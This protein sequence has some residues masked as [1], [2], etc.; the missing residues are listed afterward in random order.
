MDRRVLPHARGCEHGY[1]A[2]WVQVGLTLPHVS[3]T[4][5]L[6]SLVLAQMADRKRHRLRFR[7]TGISCNSRNV[8]LAEIVT[9]LTEVRSFD[10]RSRET[11]NDRPHQ[12]Q[13]LVEPQPSQT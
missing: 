2:K 7:F 1:A 11:L 5:V 13:P 9:L 10:D 12:L 3:P 4:R 6:M 8:T